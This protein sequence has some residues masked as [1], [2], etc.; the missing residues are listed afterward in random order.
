MHGTTTSI[1]ATG[2]LSGIA[3]TEATVDP[4]WRPWVKLLDIALEAAED[5]AWLDGVPEPAAD[6]SLG[7][8]LLHNVV[9]RVDA[10]RARRLVRTLLRDVASTDH[11]VHGRRRLD[12][13][14]LLRASIEQDAGGIGRVAAQAG[15]DED[16]L[17]AVAQLATIPLLH[18]CARRLGSS[19]PETWMHGYCPV[20]GSWPTLL[21]VRGLERNRR[22]RCGRCSSDWPI[23][24]LRCPFCAEIDHHKLHA[25]LPEGDEQ[26]RRVDVC[27]T[28]HGYIKGFSTLRPMPFRS[29]AITDLATVEL[30]LVAQERGFSRPMRAAFPL[31]ITLV[32]GNAQRDTRPGS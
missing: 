10:R 28:C 18:A 3:A 24:V 1:R 19:V 26:T 32:R 6:R 5:V 13:L 11:D 27:D 21:E 25:L 31:S 14:R 2:R 16:A 15:V 7:A 12:T 9:L 22:L 29:L 4:A 8:P 30:D 17:A 23:P 20:C